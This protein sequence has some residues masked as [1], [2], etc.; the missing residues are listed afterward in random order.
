MHRHLAI[1]SGDKGAGEVRIPEAR[2]EATLSGPSSWLNRVLVFVVTAAVLGY[3]CAVVWKVATSGDAGLRCVFGVKL[4]DDVSPELQWSR[5]PKLG[6]GQTVSADGGERWVDVRKEHGET[7]RYFWSP[8]PPIK[9]ATLLSIGG[10]PIVLYPDYIR[11]LA[12]IED[13][14]GEPIEVRWQTDDGVR[15]VGEVIVARRPTRTYL[16]LVWLLQEIVIFAVGALI[17]WHRPRNEA[18]RLFFWLCAVTVGAF[19][20]GYH[21]SEIVVFFPLI[22]LFVLFAVFVPIVTLHFYM[23]FPRPQ[24]W[25]VA[26]RRPVLTVLY[27]MPTLALVVIWAGMF[28]VRSLV[29]AGQPALAQPDLV[30]SMAQVGM[31]VQS[32]SSQVLADLLKADAEEWRRLIKQI[33]FTAES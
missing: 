20:G 24:P 8:G 5:L 21:W 6:Q 17:Y 31:E 3:S 18:A 2:A 27:A 10:Q 4:K 9:G 28:Q 22:M 13:R 1:P 7:V 19:M 23:V 32:S 16:A 14:V 33:G 26:H 25:F 11:A 12:A 30:A 15:Y 29:Q